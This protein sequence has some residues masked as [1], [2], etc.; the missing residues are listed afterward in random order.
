MSGL[1]NRRGSGAGYGTWIVVFVRV[2]YYNMQPLHSMISSRTESSMNMSRTV[3][4]S[5]NPVNRGLL[6]S[7]VF[8]IFSSCARAVE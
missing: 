5:L 6:D 8:V 7:Q 1:S 4:E 2:T 3:L